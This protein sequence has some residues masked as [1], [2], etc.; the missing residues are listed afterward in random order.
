M[1]LLWVCIEWGWACR[2]G[3]FAGTARL[4][5]AGYRF[6]IF[7][8]NTECTDDTAIPNSR[9]MALKPK[10]W[11][12]TRAMLATGAGTGQRGG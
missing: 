10:L 3:H 1:G 9:L 4:P 8:A 12:C 11:F 6:A 5:I 2:W 7:P